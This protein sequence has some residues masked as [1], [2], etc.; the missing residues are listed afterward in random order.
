MTGKLVGALSAA[1]LLAVSVHAGERYGLKEGTPEIKSAG[2]LAFGPGSVLFIGDSKSAAIFAVDTADAEGKPAEASI[3]VENIDGKI[4]SLLGTTADGIQINDLAVN[5]Q[6]GNVYLAVS[7]GQGA[8]A[9]PVILKVDGQGK[10]SEFSLENVA[11]AKAALPNP[12]EDK[13]VGEGRRSQNNREFAITDLGFVDG[14][15]IVAGL[16]NEEFSSNLRAIPFPFSDVNEG[17]SVE[18]YHGNHGQ[19]ETRSP[20]RT[21][22]PLTIGGDPQ[23]IAA[24]TCTPLVRIPVSDLKPGAKVQG[25]T[26][27]EL[28]N[29]NRPLDIISYSQG[30]KQFMLM[31]NNAR[32]VMKI[33]TDEISTREGIT[34]RVSDIAGQPYET[35]EN[36]QGVTQLD[37]L[38][39][40]AA[41]VLIEDESKAEHLKTVALP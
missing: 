15:V 33:S 26:I 11:F 40:K 34:E 16:S 18:I 21:F 31:A 39:D 9:Q 8:D 38:N 17:A 20:I 4:A 3:N 19:L 24:Y 7:R 22:I 13:V 27:A 2:T 6:S 5:P 1:L 37:K 23:I 12:P 30:G 32:G 41:V 29:R 10:V 14:R 28:G 36:L 35:I 25:T